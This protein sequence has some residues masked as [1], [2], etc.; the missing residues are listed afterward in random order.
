MKYNIVSS[1]NNI[2]RMKK[3]DN[4]SGPFKGITTELHKDIQHEEFYK[5]NCRETLSTNYKTIQFQN[6]PET[7]EEDQYTQEYLKSNQIDETMRLQATN[8]LYKL[9]VHLSFHSSNL[10]SN[11]KKNSNKK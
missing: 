10:S 4:N 7:I 6:L 8:H 9:E 11:L 2:T 1:D 3:Q 5:N